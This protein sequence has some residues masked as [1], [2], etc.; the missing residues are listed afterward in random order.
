MMLIKLHLRI[1]VPEQKSKRMTI[2]P[3]E[4]K[5]SL[6]KLLCESKKLANAAKKF[7]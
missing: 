3:F 5:N 1:G 2:F 4:I 7:D 6:S